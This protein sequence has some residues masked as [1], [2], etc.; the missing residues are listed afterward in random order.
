MVQGH[1]SLPKTIVL[2]YAQ[3]RLNHSDTWY[4]GECSRAQ[5]SFIGLWTFHPRRN[6]WLPGL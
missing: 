5:D 2:Q 6:G 1:R 4:L 3:N